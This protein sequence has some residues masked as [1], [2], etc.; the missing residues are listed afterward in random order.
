MSATDSDAYARQVASELRQFAQGV[1]HENSA[2]AT[3]WHQRH[4]APRVKA[5][6]G[7]ENRMEAKLRTIADAV[8]RTGLTDIICLGAADAE[9][10]ILHLQMADQLGLPWFR[11]HAL[12]LSPH[13]VARAKERA[14]AAG[15]ADR[16][17]PRVAD[18]N[19]GLAWPETGSM[20]GVMVANALHH[21]VNLEQLYADTHRALHPDGVFIIED[22]VGRNGHRR[23]PEALGVM[24]AL[25]R[26]LPEHLR[27][28]FGHGQPDRFYEDWDYTTEG[29]E[30]VRAQEVVPLLTPHFD[31][32][33]C[34]VWGGLA[35]WIFGAT[36]APNFDPEI[37]AHSAFINEVQY[38][39]DRLIEAR[40][41]T[42]TVLLGVFRPKQPNPPPPILWHGRDIG[43]VMRP[44]LPGLTDDLSVFGFL[45]PFPP[46]APPVLVSAPLGTRLTFANGGDGVAMRRWGWSYPEAG[47]TW[48]M[49]AACAIAFITTSAARH[50]TIES[51]GYLPPDGQTQEV[52]VRLNGTML[53]VLR[54]SRAEQ[55]GST[56][57]TLPPHTLIADGNLLEF[58]IERFRLP[59]RDGGAERR[60]I[61]FG[62]IAVT[63]N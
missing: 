60:E 31:T 22:V 39:E 63:L 21:I 42:A 2:A 57:F 30:G 19:Q 11:L 12:D 28:D 32:E 48:G 47:L 13:L 1:H 24:R 34:L 8:Q 18:L 44:V 6:F 56:I 16:L 15:Y 27:H 53:G 59:D 7:V 58:D 29:F 38:L 52:M 26:I 37:P 40:L 36:Y 45:N 35:E 33:R 46:V 41:T 43:H 51:F 23:W 50:L 55:G 17:L 20:A 61:S 49:G 62:L 14:E 9:L 3:V 4:H 10:E 25:W 54:H 5:V